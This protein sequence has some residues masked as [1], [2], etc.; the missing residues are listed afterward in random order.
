M[1]A[2]EQLY[3]LSIEF[4]S[5]NDFS[6]QLFASF[7]IFIFNFQ[8]PFDQSTKHIFVYNVHNYEFSILIFSFMII[9]LLKLFFVYL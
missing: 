6:I 1:S 7:R 2:F 8:A 9:V 4:Q 3:Y 5:I